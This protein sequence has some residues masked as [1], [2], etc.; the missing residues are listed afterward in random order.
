MLTQNDSHLIVKAVRLKDQDIQELDGFA[1]SHY[2]TGL[3]N[4]VQNLCPL[5]DSYEDDLCPACNED[6]PACSKRL[7]CNA[8]IKLFDKFDFE[9]IIAH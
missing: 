1:L 5:G 3:L 2:K 4:A 8:L 7:A 9:A 6:A